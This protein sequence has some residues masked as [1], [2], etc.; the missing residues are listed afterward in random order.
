[1]LL[2]LAGCSG[3]DASSTSDSSNAVG[4]APSDDAIAAGSTNGTGA[5]GA[6]GADALPQGIVWCQQTADQGVG[7]V[8]LAFELVTGRE[9]SQDT[10]TAIGNYFLTE[11]E[12]IKYLGN[13]QAGE[14]PLEGEYESQMQACLYAGGAAREAS[15]HMVSL[16]LGEGDDERHRRGG[17]R[18]LAVARRWWPRCFPGETP[19]QSL[20]PP[21]D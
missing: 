10:E 4:P 12:C 14:P 13:R 21:G 11:F 15:S 3:D 19:P 5:T 17:L 7:L 20:A 2:L 18:G 16:A 1:M 9:P 6:T 8:D